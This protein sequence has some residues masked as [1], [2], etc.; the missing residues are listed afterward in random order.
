MNVYL[1]QCGDLI[2]IGM[3]NKPKKRRWQVGVG[4]EHRVELLQ[5]WT[6]EDEHSAF[7]AERMAHYALEHCRVE[8]EWFRC[9]K[10]AALKAIRQAVKHVRVGNSVP[11]KKR[12]GLPN[13]WKRKSDE[14]L[15]QLVSRR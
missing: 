4:R 13:P 3:S 1:M 7:T 10:T 15:P 9:S 12:D 14:T 2:K 11:Y 8:G 6:M 5:T